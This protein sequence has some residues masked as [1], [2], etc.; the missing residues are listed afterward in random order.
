MVRCEASVTVRWKHANRRDWHNYFHG[1]VKPLA[2]ALASAGYLPDDTGDY[3]KVVTPFEFQYVRDWPPNA[4]H[5]V[6]LVV[7][8]ECEYA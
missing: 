6:E 2:D 7:L 8:L 3:F 4:L 1:I 5:K